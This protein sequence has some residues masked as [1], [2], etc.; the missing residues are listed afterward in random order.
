MWILNQSS[1]RGIPTSSQDILGLSGLCSTLTIYPEVPS[2]PLDSGESREG[3][4]HCVFLIR[5]LS[6]ASQR[7]PK[8]SLALQASAPPSPLSLG[9]PHFFL[10]VEIPGRA[11]AIVE[12]ESDSSRGIPT[13]YRDILGPLGLS[14]NLTTHSGVSSLPLDSGE[15]REGPSHCGF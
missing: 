7:P 1:S 10:T 11:Q 5:A 2:L 3:P 12:F 6:G 9:S 15:S 14:P 8:I 4:S 13:S